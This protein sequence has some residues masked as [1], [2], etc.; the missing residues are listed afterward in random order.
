MKNWVDFEVKVEVECYDNFILSCMFI[1]EII[2]E[3]KMVLLYVDL[4]EIFEIVD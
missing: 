2:E 3:K 4:V 1:L